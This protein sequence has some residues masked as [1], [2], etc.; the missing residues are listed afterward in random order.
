MKGIRDRPLSFCLEN[1][2]NSI[3]LIEL[4][5]RA[6]EDSFMDVVHDTRLSSAGEG[7]V[8]SSTVIGIVR[9][10]FD[11]HIRRG[12]VYITRIAGCTTRARVLSNMSICMMCWARFFAASLL[13]SE[14]E[15]W[16]SENHWRWCRCR[17][18]HLKR[19]RCSILKGGP[20][21]AAGV[22]G[23]LTMKRLANTDGKSKI[24]SD[25]ACQ[26]ELCLPG[27]TRGDQQPS[28]GALGGVWLI[29]RPSPTRQKL[30]R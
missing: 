21:L 17:C 6:D 20:T 27:L 13:V 16:L 11:K 8:E 2:T 24:K 10:G 22:T 4:I 30:C 15:R 25:N 9:G 7:R 29:S 28:V 5:S 14:D 3:K 19:K 26:R 23:R 1:K 12:G 18:V